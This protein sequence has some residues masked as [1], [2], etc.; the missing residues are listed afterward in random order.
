M[1]RR[2][3]CSDFNPNMGDV[4]GRKNRHNIGSYDQENR[5]VGTAVRSLV[6]RDC[7]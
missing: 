4:I 1:R 7:A 3:G 2:D 5:Y 6:S